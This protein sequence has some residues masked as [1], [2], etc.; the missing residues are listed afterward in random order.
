V[1]S[2]F[3]AEEHLLGLLRVYHHTHDD[4]TSRSHIS[5]TRARNAAFRCERA[6]NVGTYVTNMYVEAC[7]SKRL[8]HAKPYVAQPNYAYVCHR[9]PHR[10]HIHGKKIG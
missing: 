2:A 9:S 5:R 1:Y 7:A 10:A 4:L 6:S 3:I 8:R